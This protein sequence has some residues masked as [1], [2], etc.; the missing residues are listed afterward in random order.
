M[1]KPLTDEQKIARAEYKRNYYLAN[2]ERLLCEQKEYQINNKERKKEYDKKYREYNKDKL[3]EHK[4]KWKAN[5]K[6]KIRL[7]NKKYTDNNKDKIKMYRKKYKNEQFLNNPIYKLK[8]SLRSMITRSF[9]IKGLHKN[10][11]TIEILGCSFEDFKTYLE[12]LWEPWMNWDNKG[13][14]NGYPKTINISWDIDHIIPLS[15]ATT[16]EDVI[17]LNHYTNLQPLCSY[18]NRH[19]KRGDFN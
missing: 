5:N 9:K 10:N 14:W 18:T 4:K 16:E 17:K 13:N 8:E 12:S 1:R 3:N 7:T 19:I 6:Y 2:K 15:I 11:K